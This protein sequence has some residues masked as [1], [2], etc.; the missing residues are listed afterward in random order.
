MSSATEALN[1]LVAADRLLNN[2]NLPTRERTAAYDLALH[3]AGLTTAVP[4]RKTARKMVKAIEKASSYWSPTAQADARKIVG[5][6]RTALTDRTFNKRKQGAKAH[7]FIDGTKEL[8]R[9]QPFR[10]TAPWEGAIARI[11]TDNVVPGD[12]YYYRPRRGTRRVSA[13]GALQQVFLRHRST[14]TRRRTSPR[15]RKTRSAKGRRRNR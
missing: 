12:W 2:T 8:L 14:L 15:P 5:P 13:P 10:N 3:H 7:Q 6:V 11:Q 1:R 4:P 9:Q